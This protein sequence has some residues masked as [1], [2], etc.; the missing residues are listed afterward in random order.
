M[1]KNYR[2]KDFAII[3]RDIQIYRGI[4]DCSLEK[5]NIPYLMDNKKDIDFNPLM[6]LVLS[7]LEI[8]NTKFSSDYVLKY[9]KSGISGF[10]IDEISLIENYIFLWN[11]NGCKWLTD[12]NDNPLILEE[13]QDNKEKILSSLN[14]LRKK[15]IDPFVKLEEKIKLRSCKGISKAIYDFLVDVNARDNLEI[16]VEE[17]VNLN[18]RGSADEQ[19]KL[20]DILM[21]I[22]DQVVDILGDSKIELSRYIELLRLLI[23]SHD[24]NID[25]TTKKL[26]EVV[27]GKADEIQ[28]DDNA[29]IVFIIGLNSGEFPKIPRS[30]GIFS[31]NERKELLNLKLNLYGSLEDR[32]LNERFLAYKSLTL[33]SEKLYLSFH[34]NNISGGLKFPSEIIKNVKQ[35]LPNVKVQ[36]ENFEFIEDGIWSEKSAF[37]ICSKYWNDD[38]SFSHTLKN[39]FINKDSYLEKIK[40]LNETNSSSLGIFKNATSIFDGNIKVS[41]S[42]IEKYYLCKFQYFCKYGILAKPRKKIKFS[43]LEYGKI[44]HFVLE[45]IFSKFDINNLCL[46]SEKDLNDKIHEII[47]KYNKESSIGLDGNPE[48]LK[49]LF[50]K[51][52]LSFRFL[53]NHINNELKQSCFKAVDFELKIGENCSIK[54]SKLKLK[55][56]F[57]LEICGKIDRIDVMND[58]EKNYI[59]IIDYKTRSK[60][61]NLSD[62][63]WGYNTQ[64]LIYLYVILKQGKTKYGNVLPA[65]ILYMPSGSVF[66]NSERNSEKEK[67]YELRSKNYKMNGFI[68]NDNKVIYGMEKEAKGQFIPV[69]MKNGKP[70]KE[71]NLLN[72]HDIDFIMKYIE[73]LILDMGNELKDGNLNPNPVS[74]KDG[75]SCDFCEYRS[76]CKIEND[77]DYKKINSLSKE[78][79]LDKIGK[80]I[81][82]SKW[83]T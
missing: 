68:L 50:S 83:D 35:I 44:M 82:R 77:F 31:E 30:N 38:S 78:E 37:E 41:A 57:Y 8:I 19:I 56:D 4:I 76:V 18:R 72:L 11:I 34:S 49:C 6:N 71:D 36:Y 66:V 69:T 60:T 42:Q 2:Y 21:E 74:F 58:G 3:T 75:N 67:I 20:W 80:E 51:F 39:Y 23:N 55:D 61:F 81:G 63:A 14:K 7:I 70:K 28:T 32:S 25:P 24:I 62:I 40:M 79:F 5:Y 52:I 27:I 15:I 12:F 13:N 22:L 1:E 48:K 17:L 45:N 54:P 16:F 46:L 47:I 65:G 29:K 53:I 73:K 43:S 64:M 9:L 10:T 33:A 26:D 59:R